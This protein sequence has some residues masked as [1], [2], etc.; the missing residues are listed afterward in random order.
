MRPV[1]VHVVQATLFLPGFAAVRGAVG[2]A[3]FPHSPAM[4]SHIAER[5]RLQDVVLIAAN[6]TAHDLPPC[7]VVDVR[8]L[9]RR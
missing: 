9:L 8:A 2:V 7:L 4:A 3:R 6:C 5:N 1:L